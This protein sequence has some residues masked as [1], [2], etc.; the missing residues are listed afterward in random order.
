MRDFFLLAIL[1]I[2]LYAM[3]KRPFIA[4]GMWPWT[5][6]FFP[7][8]W[9]YGIAGSIR[10]NLLIA[11]VTIFGYLVMKNKPKVTFGVLGVLVLTFFLWTT[12]STMVTIGRPEVA[13]VFWNRFSKV[14]TL[15]V[16][17]VLIVEKK[18]HLD[19]LLWG[20]ALSVGFYGTV[21][22]L[23]FVLSGGN[24]MI[25]GMN[26]HVLG[27]RNELAVAFVMTLPICV[28][29]LGE[30]GK[31]ARILQLGLIGVMSMLVFAV[32]GTQSR[33]GFIA[34]LTL[35]GYLFMKSERKILLS[36]L[37][38]ILVAVL[39]NFVSSDY[40]SRMDTIETATSDSSFMGRVVVWKL[41]FIL[42]MENPFFGGGFKAIENFSVASR[43]A[44]EFF[45]Y[46][47][48]YTG[49]ELPQTG[50]ARAAHSIYF[51]VLGDQGFGGLALYLGCLYFSWSKAG[52]AAR[53]I[54]RAGGA[55]WLSTVSTSIQLSIFSFA[56]GGAALSFAYFDLIFTLFG[57][58]IVLET[59]LVPAEL[60]RLAR[61]KAAAAAR[62]TADTATLAPSTL[63]PAVVSTQGA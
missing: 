11:G 43:M 31:R 42:A 35:G 20:V 45:S 47:W 17:V 26:G 10:Y 28:Y 5:A 34:L 2:L 54:R 16:F 9:V 14:I 3:F 51:Q 25:A 23:K 4:L 49:D 24:H 33:G 13:W 38:I 27:D 58:V 7:N 55:R 52:K 50:F 32:V 30:Y 63:Q 46:P 19:V 44:Q 12:L 18:L 57:L 21:E 6:L 62:A 37:I 59:R 48:F 29:L 53:T 22:A 40:T 1:P 56:V 41:S 60:K 39:A 8:G 36:V 15:F 61:V